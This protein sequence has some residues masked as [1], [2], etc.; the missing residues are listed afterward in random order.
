RNVH[1]ITSSNQ[2]QN[3][4][5]QVKPKP[6]RS[7]FK[8]RPGRFCYDQPARSG[9]EPDLARSYFKFRPGFDFDLAGF[10]MISLP[11]LVLKL[12]K[13]FYARS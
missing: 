9:F 12:T 1:E 7:Y 3:Q 13:L 6:A 10:V 8:F 5:W 11:G 2:S 4:T